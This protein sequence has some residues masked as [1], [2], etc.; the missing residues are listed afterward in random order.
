[1]YGIGPYCTEEEPSQEANSRETS[2]RMRKTRAYCL[3]VDIRLLTSLED[4]ERYDRW[5]RAHPDGSLWQ[6]VEWKAFQEALGREVWP[7]AAEKNGRIVAT[8]LVIID[9]GRTGSTW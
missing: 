8:A 9:K 3:P 7:Y 2:K 6:S 4:L 5:V 1:M